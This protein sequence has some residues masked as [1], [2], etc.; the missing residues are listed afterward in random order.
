MYNEICIFVK[1]PQKANLRISI[2]KIQK[3]GFAYSTPLP[4]NLEGGFLL[5][6]LYNSLMNILQ[7]I[8]NDHYEEM[9]YILHS[10]QAVIK[11]FF[12]RISERIDVSCC[13][14]CLSISVSQDHVK[15]IRMENSLL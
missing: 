3:I 5:L 13:G 14:M 4:L 9:L 7:T 15:V 8:F 12:S 1:H 2:G 11:F 6:F 10:R